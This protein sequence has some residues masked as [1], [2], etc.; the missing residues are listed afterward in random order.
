[1][2]GCVVSINTFGGTVLPFEHN[3]YRKRNWS[4]CF[5]HRSLRLCGA[6][7]IADLLADGRRFSFS[8]AFV[9]SGFG[10]DD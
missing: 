3:E 9:G 4:D 1:M 10:G 2:D 6:E 7:A 5:D 8:G